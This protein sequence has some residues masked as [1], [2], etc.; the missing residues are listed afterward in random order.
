MPQTYQIT[1]PVAIEPGADR[2]VFS[3][4][5]T[6]MLSGRL[7]IKDDSGVGML[8]TGAT[9]SRSKLPFL[10]MIDKGDRL[11]EGRQLYAEIDYLGLDPIFDR[12]LLPDLEIQSL[13]NKERRK[14]VEAQFGT[15]PLAA[16]ALQWAD[17]DGA[18]DLNKH[19]GGS[20]DGF[21]VR[22]F[23]V[24]RAVKRSAYALQG[25]AMPRDRS[26]P[27]GMMGVPVKLKEYFKGALN[28]FDKHGDGAFDLD[29]FRDAFACFACSQLGL[30]DVPLPDRQYRFFGVPDSSLF[31]AF[32]EAA[33]WFCELFPE[34]ADFW[35]P[36]AQIFVGATDTFVF[37]FCED[38]ARH[39]QAYDRGPL[40]SPLPTKLTFEHIRQCEALAFDALGLRFGRS[41]A[42]AFRDEQMGL[43]VEA[44]GSCSR[45]TKL[46]LLVRDAK[47]PL[48]FKPATDPKYRRLERDL[49]AVPDLLRVKYCAFEEDQRRELHEHVERLL[50]SRRFDAPDGALLRVDFCN[51]VG[52][53][54]NPDTGKCD[55]RRGIVSYRWRLELD[56]VEPCRSG[57]TPD[58]QL[59]FTI[60]TPEVPGTTG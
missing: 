29:T 46:L 28:K 5:Q 56:K 19:K 47:K 24:D 31:F 1:I 33:L 4:R 17:F 18:T 10:M 38:G 45:E 22:D 55:Y 60:G 59:E 27:T 48:I 50:R 14:L 7:L 15:S 58:T 49:L 23:L 6:K 42:S 53:R 32:A 52:S 21:A 37:G 35:M 36:L 54:Y 9:L 13:S 25:L 20:A 40:A 12:S 3:Y 11:P 39:R 2:L 26:I 44:D 41:V 8:E 43:R 51:K 16:T 34:D 57:S 30:K